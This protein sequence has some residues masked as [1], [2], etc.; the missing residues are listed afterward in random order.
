[1]LIRLDQDTPSDKIEGNAL[2]IMADIVALFC[3]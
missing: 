2:P 1:M 3:F